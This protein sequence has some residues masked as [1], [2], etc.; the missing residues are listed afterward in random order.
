MLPQR[1][2][3]LLA[4]HACEVCADC[5]QIAV[6]KSPPTHVACMR[7]RPQGPLRGL[8]PKLEQ[9]GRLSAMLFRFVPCS[10]FMVNSAA[11]LVSDFTV[12]LCPADHLAEV[13]P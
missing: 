10:V 12:D 2:D 1:S 3:G 4:L 9:P 11:G 13:Q 8:A 7:A 5:S 6:P